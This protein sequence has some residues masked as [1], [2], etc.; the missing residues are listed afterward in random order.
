MS[1]FVNL[2]EGPPSNV[3]DFIKRFSSSEVYF[4]KK[5]LLEHLGVLANHRQAQ[6]VPIN[7]GQ[8]I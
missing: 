3:F 7:C 8:E 2:S 5:L 4:I 6:D 1:G